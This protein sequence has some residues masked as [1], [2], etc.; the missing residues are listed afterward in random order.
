MSSLHTVPAWTQLLVSSSS[1][2]PLALTTG[3][4]GSIYMAGCTA[5]SV[6][7]QASAGG[8]DKFLQKYNTDGSKAWTQLVGSGPVRYNSVALT[9]GADGAIYMAGYTGGSMDGQANAGGYDAFIT[10]YY[11][12][13]KKAWT[14]LLGSSSDDFA[15]SLTTGADGAIYMAG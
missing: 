5:G 4:D 7:G 13:G 2:G 6:D 8:G 14:R 12:D 11:P 9:T 3:A 15:R 10:K 1:E